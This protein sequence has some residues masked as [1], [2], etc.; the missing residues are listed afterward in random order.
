MPTCLKKKIDNES[1]RKEFFEK[2]L[3]Q[4]ESFSKGCLFIFDNFETVHNPLEMFQWIE[5]YIKLPN[6]ILITTRHRGFKGD[7]P[8]EVEG[9]TESESKKLIERTVY[10][11]NIDKGLLTADIVNKIIAQSK[12]HPYII[13]ILIGELKKNKNIQSILSRREDILT[14]LFERTYSNLSPCAQRVFMT[15]ANWNSKVPKIALE[16]VLTCSLEGQEPGIVQEA[17]E[18]LFD[19]SMAQETGDEDGQ[20]FIG[21]PVVAGYFGK[22]KIKISP[23]KSDIERDIKLLQLFGPTQ[24]GDLSLNFA[25]QLDRFIQNVSNRIDGDR[26]SFNEY[27]QILD[28]VCQVYNKGRLLLSDLHIELEDM[29]QAKN[30]LELFLENESGQ[31]RENGWRKLS[32]ICFK[33]NDY[34]KY[35]HAIV[36]LSKIDTEFFNELSNAANRL[37]D[38]FSNQSQKFTKEEKN[39]LA[40]PLLS[41]LDRKKTKAKA[42][43]F[44]RMA[45]LSIC[46]DQDNRARD[47]VNEGLND[48][49]NNYHCLN[50]RLKLDMT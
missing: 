46:I 32:E 43:D 36:E 8:L 23:L 1:D 3:E 16:A 27:K 48:N 4:S 42:D 38:L 45:W 34:K 47:Y 5:T 9:M 7:Y 14:A 22:K 30:E 37:N 40:G 29:E 6:K 31:D 11:L 25:K 20:E 26:K 39:K 33:T 12:G 19:Y 35:V 17:I 2:E 21:L 28:I 24:G 10:D 18:S 49:P 44:S 13:K 41:E 50:L 15:L